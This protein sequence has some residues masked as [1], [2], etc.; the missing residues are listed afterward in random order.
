MVTQV[1]NIFNIKEI[2]NLNSSFFTA[3]NFKF[4]LIS[5]TYMFNLMFA[6]FVVITLA[7]FGHYS[8]AG[9]LG[10]VTSFWITV[11]QIFSRQLLELIK[12]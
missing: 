10:L 7:A 6:S 2:E 12:L 3:K 9:E 1:T 4:L 5:V 11:T 8:I